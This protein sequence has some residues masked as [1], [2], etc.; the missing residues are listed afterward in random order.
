MEVTFRVKTGDTP[1]GQEITHEI[2]FGKLLN[3]DRDSNVE[4]KAGQLRTYTL[5]PLDVDV[6]IFSFFDFC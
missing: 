3:E 5:K 6:D 4:W 1:D 2:D